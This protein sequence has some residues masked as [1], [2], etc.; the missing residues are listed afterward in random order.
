MERSERDQDFSLSNQSLP[1]DFE[2]DQKREM[3][4][5]KDEAE[6]KRKIE[7]EAKAQMKRDLDA[8]KKR[9]EEEVA[10]RVK[11]E[12]EAQQMREK[13]E[14]AREEREKM[15]KLQALLDKATAVTSVDEHNIVKVISP[16]H[17]IR[18]CS[19]DFVN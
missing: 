11:V 9:K 13:E 18:T 10:R 6:A 1:K 4:K 5:K 2:E 14:M 12:H 17:L 3:Q 8:E 19:L 7:Q 16:K 15:D